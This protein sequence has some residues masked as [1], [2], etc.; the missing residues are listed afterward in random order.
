MAREFR[1]E[2]LI[3]APSER[4]W[5]IVTDLERYRE[6][7]PFIP[8]ARGRI[9]AGGRIE[10]MVVPPG[11]K[12]V[13]FRP[14]VLEMEHGRRFSWLGRVVVPGLFD[15]HRFFELHDR[16]DGTVRFVQRERITGLLVPLIWRRI[17]GPNAEGYRQMNDTHQD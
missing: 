1:S 16:G 5:G 8:S 15:G 10:I 13:R 2:I 6:W 12:P 14:R 4:V 9:E 17:A 11:L 7:N 3:S